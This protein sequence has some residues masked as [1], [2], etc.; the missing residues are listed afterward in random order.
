MLKVFFADYYEDKILDSKDAR[1]ATKEE[2]LHSMDCVLHMPSNFIGVTDQHGVTLQFM[3]NDDRTIHID[4]PV[5]A[6]GGSYVRTAS[7]KE[8]LEMMR[9]L[10]DCTDIE[11]IRGLK[12]EAW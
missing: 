2:I 3:V 5:P 4:V 10:G 6:Q 8:C 7:L 9:V 11:E 1:A 12:F